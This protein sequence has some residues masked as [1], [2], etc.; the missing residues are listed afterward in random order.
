MC[1]EDICK[2]LHADDLQIYKV[3]NKGNNLAFLIEVLFDQH[4]FILLISSIFLGV[5]H[6][7]HQAT[8]LRG[9]GAKTTQKVEAWSF[10]S[11]QAFWRENYPFSSENKFIL[12]SSLLS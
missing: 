10:L 4:S 9:S 8:Q 6:A 7:Y 12:F 2:K 11:T 5:Y 3:K 1:V